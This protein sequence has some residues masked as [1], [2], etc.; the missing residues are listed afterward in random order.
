MKKLLLYISFVLCAV[1]VWSQKNQRKDYSIMLNG[2][3]IATIDD[4]RQKAK[5]LKKSFNRQK[6]SEVYTLVQFNE[7]LTVVEQ[8]NLKEQ[9]LQLLSYL[10]NNAYYVSVKS[11]FFNNST[12][13][14]IR[15]I[16]EVE[17]SLKIDQAIINRAI[18]DYA[19]S[20]NALKVVVHFFKG[21]ESINVSNTFENLNIKKVK[22]LESFNQAYIE[23][24][25]A[26]IIEIAKLNW[27]Q[28]IEL[29]PP[30]VQSDNIPG[31]TSH[32][33][34]VLGSNIDALGYGLT[35]KDVKVGIWDSNVEAHKDH[36]GRLITKEYEMV[37]M[38]GSHVSGTVAGAG[39]LDPNAKGMAPA[40][41]IYGWNFNTQSNLLPVFAEREKNTFEDGIEITSNSY[42]I[43][44]S[45]GFNTFRYDNNDRGD[46]DVMYKY[47][48]LL[49]V[50]SNGNAQAAN[51]G[52]FNTST[53]NSKNAL[54]VAANDP[55]DLISSYSSFG[56]TID[57]RLVPQ[58]ATIG[59]NVYSI[60]YN[61]LY[62]FLS[63]TSMATPGASGTLALLYERYK[64]IYGT[65]PLASLMKGLVTNTAKDVGNPGPDYKYG[66]GNL[67]GLRAVKALDNRQFYTASVVSGGVNQQSIV[68]PAGLVTLKVMLAYTDRA[69]T[70][71]AADILVNNLD[72]KLVRNGVDV[73]PWVLNPAQP[74]ANAT[75]GIDNLNNI[76]QITIDNPVAGT[77][78]IVVTGT[79][80]PLDTQEFAV[81]YDFVTPELI[82]TY[83]IGAE[84]FNPGVSEFIRWDYE[85]EARSFNLEYSIDGGVN[86]ISIAKDIPSNARNFLWNVPQF[87]V[88]TAIIRI[89]AGSA[90]DTSKEHFT[91]MS[92]PR[93]L[94]IAA[95]SCGVSSYTLNWSPT[96]GARYEVLRLNGNQ[97]DLVAT[98]TAPTYTFSN[99]SEGNNNWFTVRAIDI[100]SLA[101]SDRARA[102]NV[103]PIS[104]PVLTA[105]TIPFLE[106]FNNRKAANYTLS[107]ASN[108]GSIGFESINQIFLDAIKM[109]GNNQASPTAW[110]AS[111]TANAFANNP[112][113][114]KRLT[115]CDVDAAA[116][117]GKNIRVRF[118]LIWNNV[119]SNKSFFRVLVNG[120]PITSTDNVAVYGGTTLTGNRVVAYDLAPFAGTIFS[121]VLESVIDNDVII[122]NNVPTY[123]VFRIDNVEIFEATA[124]DVALTQ[125][126]ARAANGLTAAEVVT[127]RVYNFS[128]VAVS[129]VPVSYYING[130]AE[131]VEV[132]PGPIN[133][134]SEV[135]YN[136]NQTANYAAQNLYTVVGRVN[137]PG[138]TVATNNT[139][140]QS[141]ANTGTDILMGSVAT[142]TTCSATLTDSG[143]RFGNYINNLNQTATFVPSVAG[144]SIK[145]DFTAFA[146]EQDYDY[147]F[148]YD[149]GNTSAPLL[150]SYTGNTLPPSLTST[151]TGGQLTFR[152]ISDFTEVDAGWMANISC[153]PR[154]TVADVGI[155][156]IIAPDVLGSKTSRTDITIR[157]TNFGN[158]EVN[159]IPVFYQI[160]GGTIITETFPS[161]LRAAASVNYTFVSKAN[162]SIPGATYNI[163]AG[164]NQTDAN[165][166]NNSLVKVVYNQNSLPTN[167][168]TNGYA[169]SR[170][171]FNDVVNV[172]STSAY[173]NFK[174]IKIP[175]YPGFFYQPEVTLTRP[176][177]PLTSS[178]TTAV[179]VFTIIVIDFNGDGN[180][181]D[182]FYAGNYW[183]NT[184][185]TSSAP[186][187]PSNTS[188]HFFRNFTTSAAGITIPAAT[189]PGEKLMRILHMFRSPNE[190]FNVN[191]GPTF[192]GITTSRQ[193]FEIEEYTINVLPF[194]AADVSVDR[195]V[196]PLKPGNRPVA[197][198][199][200]I[201]NYS[202]VPIANIPIAFKVNG[203][204]EVIET[205]AGP[206]AVGGVATYNFTA[207]ADA[208]LP[209]DYTLEVYTKLAGDTDTTNDTK[210]ISFTKVDAI[211]TN[212]TG[213]FDGVNDYMVTDS[214]PAL[215]L[216]NNY[217][218]EAWIN[219]KSPTVLGRIFDKARVLLFVHNNSSLA[220]YQENSLV[221]NITT[222]AGSYILNTGLNSIRF[223]KWH[224]VAVSVSSLNV[225]TIYIDGV[226]VP[227]SQ[228]GIAAAASTNAT[229]PLFV[230]NNSGL[231]RGFNGSIDE[232]RIWSGVRDQATIASNM[233]TKYVGNE[234][235]L[236]AYYPFNEGDKQFVYDAT[237]NDNAA[238]VV[239]ADT[240]GTGEGK[241]WNIPLLLQGV[242]FAN[243]LSSSYDASSRTFTVL[244]NNSGNAAS[245]VANYNVGMNSLVKING[246]TQVNGVT[247][248]NFSNP[249][250][251][252][253]E[254]VGFNTGL[255]ENY[256]I[257]VLGGLNSQSSLL[258]YNFTT[259]DNAGLLQPINTSIVG[260][261]AKGT[262]PFGTNITSLRA[263]FTVS[264]GAE[265][266]IDGVKQDNQLTT[267]LNYSTNKLITVVSE[268]K[269]I[270]TSYMIV[271]NANNSEANF[272]SF[273][274]A[275]QIGTTI[276]DQ[277]VRTVRVT[278]NNNANLASLVPNFQVSA[279]AAARIGTYPQSSGVTTLN[280]TQPIVY[281]VRAQNGNILNWTITV[282]RAKP[283]ITLLGNAIVNV[284]KTCS[285]TEPG[286]NAVDNLNNNINANVTTT[287]VVDVNTVG[288]YILTY[289]ATDVLN[290]QSSI[291]RTVNV[292]NDACTLG[293]DSNTI[294]GLLI[295][296]N[297]VLD[298]K[299]F[300]KTNKA[301]IKAI[302]IF[303]LLGKQILST[304]TESGEINISNIQQ[305]I[306]IMKVTQDDSAAVQKLII[307]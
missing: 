257:R 109:S 209:A 111:T 131:V 2:N 157:I 119:A 215:D 166:S 4:F 44:L 240:N 58:I 169:I 110:I 87:A 80:I 5:D 299:I 94:S 41:E 127:A 68:V 162:L 6:A 238:I 37:N 139:L 103:E 180:V 59:S 20:G 134:L 189:T 183:V 213:T 66:F 255:T 290:N 243:Q 33:A 167:V 46:D 70:V 259:A 171:R 307:E 262:A 173:S 212:A 97:F 116:L 60:D 305:G 244:L 8:K 161:S 65:R 272:L 39:L 53:K 73:L 216:T 27:V 120:N 224:H 12:S 81:I 38:H 270:S 3:K 190:M 101:T 55:N 128:P 148:V 24:P 176:E 71:G 249:L 7:I 48:Y 61:N 159:N 291:T 93:N 273:A 214:T 303:D 268:D 64:N 126:S 18:P 250:P 98:V 112:N 277:A 229:L 196:T 29:V 10:G 192:D 104:R 217:T 146:L 242:T 154:P 267:A 85:G 86:Y 228:T 210:T 301:G 178:A 52:G 289:T 152:F 122:V 151:A 191:L 184:L 25:E 100:A 43:L 125:F 193:D 67:N 200:I 181:T 133:P 121:V 150:G 95:A 117:S 247:A 256:T 168:N 265:L 42:G 1:T 233:T 197:V 174:N 218:L 221:I 220:I 21:Y 295:Y 14:K 223:N 142:V 236:L 34:N 246:V 282:E 90:V 136:F 78:Q 63:G 106:N 23:V 275:N 241:F 260:L 69:A 72:I 36:T 203:G 51:P 254:G 286:F 245:A 102:V 172:S 237:V 145:V 31:Q 13:K 75:R 187:I 153:V 225:Y 88:N 170:L 107:R 56:P 54:H 160:N 202:T 96:A 74:N 271:V 205:F 57:G 276:I 15:T 207:R 230:G 92:E 158:E 279:Q 274:V 22:I 251:I 248:N 280:Y 137:F 231:A 19:F 194:S 288:Q 108:T 164:V 105:A 234:A 83:P 147:L 300:I 156:S 264:S 45:A 77:Y 144:N 302:K 99:L 222:A 296:P 179:G 208:S 135:V 281:N 269:S 195:I 283:V 253:V 261:N 278:V 235:G 232:V 141:V 149:G 89:S 140:T 129:N 227:F 304:T 76:E 30:P 292:T 201:R 91:I 124:I 175:V 226:A 284:P 132:I 11:S 163:I 298:G 293:L 165:V 177:R 138:D 199:A 40:A 9:G 49:N 47:P 26:S 294:D 115:F 28:N 204:T 185:N 32:K 113:H 130:G 285:Y 266:L 258:S 16:I 219:Q 84:K 287:G 17:P 239:N 118:N 188:T 123:N 82:L 182:E 211:A 306:Y 143:T 186:A 206:I 114:I 252:V 155:E 62:S 50:Y 263:R 79:N 35:G 198:S 297:P